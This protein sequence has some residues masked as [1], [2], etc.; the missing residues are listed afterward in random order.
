MENV[1]DEQL[2]QEFEI[3]RKKFKR[4]TVVEGHKNS[5]KIEPYCPRCQF[6]GHKTRTSRELTSN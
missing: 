6:E 1:T 4:Y 3:K 2:K 5:V